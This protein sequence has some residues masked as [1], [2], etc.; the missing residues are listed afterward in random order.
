MKILVTGANGFIGKNLV[1]RLQESDDFE[2]STLTRDDSDNNWRDQLSE[3][4]AVIHLAGENRPSSVEKFKEGNADLTAKLCS[5]LGELEQN[6]P[7]IFSSS[8]QAEYDNYYGRS[9]LASEVYVEALSENFNNPVVIYRL[10]GVFGKWCKPNYNSVVATFCNN[11]ANDLPIQIND[12]SVLLKLVYVDEVVSSF[13]EILQR[14][15]LNGV[16]RI[17]IE[18]EYSI[19]ISALAKQI[20]AFKNCRTSFI[21][22]PVEADFIHALYAT[23]IS[24]LPHE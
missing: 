24:Y 23:Y 9:K 21:S 6:I 16:L 15:E 10:P 20:K 22:E 2:F 18:P 4:D 1:F 7:L 14:D 5:I 17:S 3:A 11:I 19:T 8:V 13:I 12:S